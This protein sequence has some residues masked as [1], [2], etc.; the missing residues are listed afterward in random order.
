MNERDPK[1]TALLFN[2]RIN[3]HDVDGLSALMT[4][5]HTFIDREDRRDGGKD[6]MAKGWRA[7]FEQFPEYRN[8]FLRVESVDDRVVILGYAEWTVGGDRDHVIWT[9]VVRDDLIAEWRVYEDTEQNRRQL[10][11]ESAGS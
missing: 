6:R 3:A 1:L 4:D 2:E 9:G 5:E 11:R 8:T 10:L 7:F